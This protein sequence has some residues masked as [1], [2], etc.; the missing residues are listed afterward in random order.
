M[1]LCN[2]RGHAAFSASQL[3]ILTEVSFKQAAFRWS[4]RRIRKK[5]R[6]EIHSGESFALM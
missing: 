2:V 3:Q 4:T 5:I 1:R 6:Y